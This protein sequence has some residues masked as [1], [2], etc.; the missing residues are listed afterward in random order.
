VVAVTQI[1]DGVFR[2]EVEGRFETVYI[3]G[4]PDDRWV[5][6]DGRVY[7]GDF[8]DRS[9]RARPRRGDRGSLRQSLTAPMPAKVLK[10]MV[11]AG[12]AVKKGD[13][14]VLLE[15][16]KMELP[17]RSPADGTV[18]AVACREGDLVQADAV[19]VELE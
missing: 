12:K 2:V 1:A 10:V 7:R 16:M 9:G 14:I 4:P 19:L 17:M 18:A 5:F 11:A 15:A 6:W 8:T 13:T 3:A